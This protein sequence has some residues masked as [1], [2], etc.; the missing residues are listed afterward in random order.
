MAA[1]TKPRSES[2][3]ERL[4]KDDLILGMLAALGGDRSAV[5]ERDLFLASWHAFPNTM[6]W[7]DT[8]LPNPDTF[9]ASLRR[10]DA[11]KL[12]TREGKQQRKKRRTTRKSVLDVAR[13]SVVK[14]R[15]AEGALERSGLSEPDIA[16]ISALSPP[17]GT[18][19]TIQP[20]LLVTVCVALRQRD[21]RASD[22][23][24]IV[25]M[26]FHKFPAVFA[27]GLRP[28]FPDVEKVRGGLVA[29]MRNGLL[30]DELSLTDQGRE[31]AGTLEN[32]SSVQIDASSSQR[33]GALRLAARI[34]ASHGYQTFVQTGTLVATKG[35]ELFRALRLPPTTDVRPIAEALKQR[36]R[37]LRRVDQGHIAEYLFKLAGRHNSEVL[38]LLDDSDRALA[39]EAEEQ[40]D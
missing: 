35:D 18:Y 30:T 25:E 7:T 9:T 32:L 19:A 27:Y 5:N 11:R 22:E 8:A 3:T 33:T 16:A 12:I 40:N 6:R 20:E 15:L 34:E 4:S 39:L 26:A 2:V 29:A 17:P 10:L 31:K 38:P 13:S 24:A 1:E 21:G 36:T 37:E 23:G 14:A 28:E